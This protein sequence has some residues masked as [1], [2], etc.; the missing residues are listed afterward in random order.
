MGYVDSAAETGAPMPAGIKLTAARS[1]AS[2]RFPK[3][4]L[5]FITHSFPKEIKKSALPFEEGHLGLVQVEKTIVL[6]PLSFSLLIFQNIPY[7]IR[8]FPVWILTSLLLYR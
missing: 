6:D 4:F 7:I 5:I 2:S 3:C 1:D 8:G